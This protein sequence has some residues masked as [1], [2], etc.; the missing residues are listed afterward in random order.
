MLCIMRVDMAIL[1]VKCLPR[2][3]SECIDVERVGEAITQYNGGVNV[4]VNVYT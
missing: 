3:R 4:A 1:Q 2:L